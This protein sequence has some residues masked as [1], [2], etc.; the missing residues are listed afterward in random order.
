M[1]LPHYL[2][3]S[4]PNPADKRAPWYKNTAP[5]Y[6]GIFLAVIFYQ[7][8]AAGTLSQASVGTCLLGLLVGGLIA[9]GL[10]YYA[11]AM[12][13]MKTGRPLYIVGTSTFGTQGNYLPGFLMGLLQVGFIG[14]ITLIAANYL[15]AAA[16]AQSHAAVIAIC[17]VWA[18]AL[19]WIA[20]RGISHVA[21]A[22]NILNWIPLIMLL[23]VVYAVSGGIANYHPAVTHSGTGFALMLDM[24]LGYFA[25]AGAAGADFGINSRDRRDVSLGGLFGIALAALVAGGL[26]I[27]GVAGAIGLNSA[28]PVGVASH[29]DFSAAIGSVGSAASL[30]YILFVIAL[31]P[32]CTFSTFI[33]TNSFSTMLPNAPRSVWAYAAATGGILLAITGVA[34]NLGGFF[35]LVGATFAPVCGAMT[36]D[37]LLAGKKWSGPRHGI[38]WAGYAAW[39]IGCWV[40]LLD[41][42][43]LHLAPASWQQVDHPAVLYSYI[44][45][46]VVYWVLAKAGVRPRL[47][48]E[49][50]M[51][52]AAKV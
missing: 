36:A 51:K 44:V 41:N 2:R 32:C 12:L 26:A 13:G 17:I 15:M 4:V 34:A 6:A 22:S 37:Y 8:M 46:F 18:Y 11:P 16:H 27:L 7:Q 39:I 48:A 49:A 45:A 19:A 25:T 5:A 21:R 30:V 20:M 28:L 42:P 24:V 33:A 40:G 52:A 9:W 38:N 23:F 35:G 14:V 43:G 50:E 1:A 47:V 31:L 29:F 10:F 3:A